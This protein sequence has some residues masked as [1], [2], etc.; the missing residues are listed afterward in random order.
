MNLFLLLLLLF[1]ATA[2]PVE[3]APVGY[4]RV[5]FS[6]ICFWPEG[7]E[8]EWIELYNA[9]DSVIDISGWKITWSGGGEFVFPKRMLFLKP[10]DVAVVEFNG[11]SSFLKLPFLDCV[12]LGAEQSGDVLPNF[13][14]NIQLFDKT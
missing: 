7:G 4:K 9:S 14:S 5:K 11:T 13:D 2:F 3:V 1:V 6:E 10:M 8:S 12:W